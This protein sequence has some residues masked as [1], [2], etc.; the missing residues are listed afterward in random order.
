MGME[1]ENSFENYLSNTKNKRL[2]KLKKTFSIL[3]M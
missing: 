2:T 1:T 3:Q